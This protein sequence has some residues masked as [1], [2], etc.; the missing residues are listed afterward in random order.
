MY[1][2]MFLFEDKKDSML[3]IIVKVFHCQGTKK[4]KILLLL[5]SIF[6]KKNFKEKRIKFYTNFP[7]LVNCNQP[8]FSTLI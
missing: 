4:L 7:K 5:C 6:I 1:G 8:K 3:T 2:P